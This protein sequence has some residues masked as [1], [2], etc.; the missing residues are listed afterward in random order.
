M[1]T[2]Y[3]ANGKRALDKFSVKAIFEL[4]GGG[5]GLRRF[6]SKT[7]VWRFHFCFVYNI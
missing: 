2:L 1:N 3:S 5:G 7:K 4:K 6:L